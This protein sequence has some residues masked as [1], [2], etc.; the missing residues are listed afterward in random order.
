MNRP[1]RLSVSFVKSVTRPGRYTDG[2]GSFGLSLFV[3]IGAS[4]RLSKT[5]TQKVRIG[6]RVTSIGLGGWPVVSLKEARAKALENRRLVE[7]GVDPRQPR[8]VVPTFAD[9]VDA[10]IALR[11]PSWRGSE[12]ETQWRSSLSR[13]AAALAARPVSE[14]TPSDVMAV[15]API[16]NEKPETARRLRGRLS[17]VFKWSI[18]GG[19]RQD[20]P[21]GEQLLAALPRHNGRV[22]HHPA[23]PHPQVADLLRKVRESTA[24]P[25]TRLGFELLALT[26]TRSGEV[27][28]A[29]WSEFDLETA[30]WTIP[31][32]R[33]KAKQE[34]RVPLSTAALDVLAKARRLWGG[35]G[36][37]FPGSKPRRGGAGTMSKMAWL[38]LLRR[39]EVPCTPHGLRTS[40]RI[41]A[42]ESGVDRDTAEKCL[43]HIERNPVV[44]AYM[45][46]DLL[47]A[48]RE[49]M[50]GWSD[51]VKSD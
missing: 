37:V 15:V 2:P 36:L 10:T 3:R 30:T 12:S 27:R 28:L 24:A 31:A 14:I 26:A 32:S 48:R 8:E 22:K 39:L 44:A 40:F 21:A 35:T 43:G 47:D 46:S 29:R 7:Q 4:G 23:L 13:F 51:Y 20:N 45:R 42:A 34:H 1:S 33:T 38:A 9:A 50:Q 25:A 18:A 17:A 16:W 41:W 11:R 19:H 5:W 49:V 6:D